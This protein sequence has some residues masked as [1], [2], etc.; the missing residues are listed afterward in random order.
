MWLGIERRGW[1]SKVALS[2]MVEVELEVLLGWAFLTDTQ[3]ALTD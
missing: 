3:Q 1:R 2:E